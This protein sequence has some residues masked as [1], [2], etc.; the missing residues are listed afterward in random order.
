MLKISVHLTL[1][2]I[3]AVFLADENYLLAHTLLESLSI[4]VA[5]SI[6]II[7]R[8]TQAIVRND[9][10]MFLGIVYGFVGGFDILHML[11]Y[12]GMGVFANEEAN[13]PTQLWVIARLIESFSLVAAPIF[14]YHSLNR[15]FTVYSYS[16]VSLVM[17]LSV[18]WWD[19]FPVCYVEGAGLTVF[20][21]SI[22]YVIAGLFAGAMVAIFR[23]RSKLHRNIVQFLTI[24][25]AAKFLSAIAFTAYLNI[26]SSANLVGHLLK[27]ISYYFIYKA[28]VEVSLQEPHKF[29]FFEL[30]QAK[31]NLEQANV[32]LTLEIQERRQTQAELQHSMEQLQIAHKALWDREKL[33]IIGQIAAGM[34]HEVKNPLTS[35]R[36][37]AQLLARRCS[38]DERSNEYAS[39]IVDEVDRASGVIDD[40][41]EFA[42][43]K[44]PEMSHRSLANVIEEVFHIIDSQAYLKHIIIDFFAEEDLPECLLDKNKIKQA[45]LNICQNA[46]EAMPGGGR[47][48]LMVILGEVG[49]VC[50][51]INDTGCGIPEDKINNI[52]VPF[53]TT[54]DT[55]TGLGLSIANA[56]IDAHN[57]R[58]EVESSL[59][60]GTTFRLY[61]PCYQAIGIHG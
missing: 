35:A 2:L 50:I 32:Q 12:K 21:K 30:A 41:L 5:F 52:G 34:A 10:F 42:R 53:Y 1:F 38:Q 22:E 48:S 56:I 20:K 28:I 18:F 31:Y 25:F 26:Y 36:G 9:Y 55:G 14:F 11:A 15:R 4:I 40:F 16:L 47:L 19:N 39:I 37:F 29:L 43:P 46:I 60:K 61:L 58:I 51:S 23:S 49:E 57:G 24:S 45:I 27:I 17:L 33:A 54:K 59:G 13:L 3:I 6:L 44:P 8:N 7:A